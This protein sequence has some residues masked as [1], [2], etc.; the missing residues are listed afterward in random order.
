MI[1]EYEYEYEYLMI[2]KIINDNIYVSSSCEME[3]DNLK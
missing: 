1:Y 3:V 2:D